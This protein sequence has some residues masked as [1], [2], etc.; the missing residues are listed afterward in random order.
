MAIDIRDGANVEFEPLPYG[1]SKQIL[2][3]TGG[4]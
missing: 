1:M 4:I 2:N 3:D